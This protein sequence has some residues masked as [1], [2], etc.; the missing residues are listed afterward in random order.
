MTKEKIK[1]IIVK[2]EDKMID[3]RRNMHQNSELSMKEKRLVSLL[4]LF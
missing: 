3:F 1:D 4:H 2:N